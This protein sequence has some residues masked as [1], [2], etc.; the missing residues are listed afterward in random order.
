M[1]SAINWSFVL[2]MLLALGVLAL[3]LAPY[4]LSGTKLKNFQRTMSLFSSPHEIEAPISTEYYNVPQVALAVQIIQSWFP[5]E[6]TELIPDAPVPVCGRLNRTLRYRE[7]TAEI[8]M[9][10]FYDILAPFQS[11]NFPL[12]KANARFVI[13]IEETNGLCR[14][15]YK[16]I[17]ADTALTDMF[18]SDYRLLHYLLNRVEKEFLSLNYKKS[19]NLQTLPAAARAIASTQVKQWWRT[20]NA[21]PGER[22]YS[23]WPTPQDYSE[24]VQNPSLNFMDEGVKS[25]E[26]VLNEL[27][28]PRVASGMFASVYEFKSEKEQWAVRCFTTRLKDQQERYKAISSF[29]LADD[30]PYT[31]DFH[32]LE[33]GIKCGDTWFPI[34][35]MTWVAGQTLDAYVRENLRN[36]NGLQRLRVEF[37]IMMEKLKANGV[38]HGDLQH[39]NILIS[40]DQLYL[41]DYDGFYVPEL[42]GRHNNELGHPNYQ[43]PKRSEKYFGPYLDNF[44][45]HVIDL[46]LLCLIEDPFLWQRFNGG[47]E[48]LLFRNK[49]FADPDGSKLISALQRHESGRIRAAVNR[50]LDYIKM[51]VE[52][53]PYLCR[54]ESKEAADPGEKIQITE[55]AELRQ[56]E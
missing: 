35:K 55:P 22:T 41:V 9:H 4:L 45:A 11:L 20:F 16:W 36:F 6:E 26:A 23:H 12:R 40:S 42:A 1:E 13:S 48:C 37:Q 2:W 17:G 56:T 14:F 32:Y 31:V 51:P 18:S 47:D 27:G 28:I 49:D 50:L 21:S 15:S 38:A 54:E 53:I 19:E 24:A 29:I 5:R 34:L 44:S 8:E 39:G 33:D 7:G 30:L 10:V 3:I 52:E 46:S 43:H 25:C